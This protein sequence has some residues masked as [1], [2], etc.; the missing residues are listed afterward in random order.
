AL[1]VLQQ[2][3]REAGAPLW[4]ANVDYR[5]DGDFRYRG[6]SWRVQGTPALA[7]AHQRSNAA[8]ACALLEA[9]ARQGLPVGPEHAAQGLS[10]ARWPGRLQRIGERPLVLLDGAHNPHAAAALASSLGE[11]L[12][13]RPLQLVFGALADKDAAAMLAR[14]APLAGGVHLCA[15]D[16]P[17][18]QAPEQLVPLARAANPRAPAQA[19]PSAAAALEAARSAAGPEGTVLCCGSLYLI[20]ELLAV[21]EGTSRPMPGERL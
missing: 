16:S 11:L 9:A 15:P 12:R 4:I 8:L 10:S 18:A 17:R 19:H 5:F 21:A 7:G 20:G 3:A 13:G 6:P 2:A 1:P 14:L